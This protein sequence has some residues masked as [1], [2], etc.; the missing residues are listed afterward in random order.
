M[1]RQPP[2]V[3]VIRLVA[4]QIEKLTIVCDENGFG[5]TK[6]IISLPTPSIRSLSAMPVRIPQMLRLRS[7][8]ASRLKTSSFTV[9]FPV[10]R[11]PKTAKHWEV[12]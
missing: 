3:E 9:L 1:D 4:E 8:T 12:L 11:L 2:A 7:M 6:D 10:R 5:Q